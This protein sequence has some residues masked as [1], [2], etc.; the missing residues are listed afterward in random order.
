MRKR[1]YGDM[2]WKRTIRDQVEANPTWM[3]P[4]KNYWKIEIH[5]PMPADPERLRERVAFARNLLEPAGW[6]YLGCSPHNS[7]A[8]V[9]GAG[10]ERAPAPEGEN[11]V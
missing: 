2:G 7:N 11:A 10:F 4:A 6:R 1:Q 9:A 3:K 8:L 5:F